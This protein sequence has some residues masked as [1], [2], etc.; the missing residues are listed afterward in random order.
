MV[1]QFRK[2]ITTL[3]F[4]LLSGH[5]WSQPSTPPLVLRPDAPDRYV[6][7]PGDTLWGI[8]GRYTDS[9][10]RWPEL[11]GMN[12][13]QIQNP[14]LIYP[15]YV[16]LLDREKGRLTIGAPGT[17]GTP[18]T[19]VPAAPGEPGVTRGPTGSVRLGPRVR[20]ESLAR[21]EIPSI[22]ASVIEPFLTRPLVIEPEGLD[23]APTIVATQADRVVLAAGNSAYVRGIGDSTQESWYVY[24]RGNALVDPDTDR[25]LAYEA[26]YLGTAQLARGGDPATVVLTSA[27]QE[28]GAGDKLIAAGIPQPINYAPHSPPTYLKGRVM[29]IYGG[30]GKVGEAGPQQVITINRGKADGIEIGHV[31]ALYSLGGTVTDTTRPRGDP[32][33]QIKLPDERAGLAFVFRVFERVSYALIMQVTRPVLPLDVVQTP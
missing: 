25:V 11:W 32:T 22:P 20:A 28:V 16:I 33:A 19:G 29:S 4:F 10:W 2:S 17:P 1:Q 9:P 3:I 27:V 6:V 26:I 14:H 15:G 23:K 18:G 13:E 5:A 7:V 8:S 31:L 24:R 30:L 12:R 21:Q